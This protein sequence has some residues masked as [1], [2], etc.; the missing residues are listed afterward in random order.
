MEDFKDHTETFSKIQFRV[1]LSTTDAQH[2]PYVTT[3]HV[4]ID[5]PD[6]VRS[7]RSSIPAAG[8]MIEYGF[9]YAVTPTVVATADTA[10]ARAVIVGTPGTTSCTIKIFDTNNTA[11]AGTVN[12][13]A[14]GY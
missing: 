6:V 11:I 9:E 7:G 5:M 3:L 12:W 2:P 13:T 14:Y 1:V 8:A 4:V 10:T